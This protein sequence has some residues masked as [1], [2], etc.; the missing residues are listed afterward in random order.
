MLPEL[1][2]RNL[3]P[4]TKP[5]RVHHAPIPS[6]SFPHLLTQ[7]PS[8]PACTSQLPSPT[9]SSR[10]PATAPPCPSP[11]DTQEHSHCRCSSS[12]AA[13]HRPSLQ[14]Q[15]TWQ[16]ALLTWQPGCPT[17]AA[18]QASSRRPLPAAPP[19]PWRGSPRGE[20]EGWRGAGW[21]APLQVEEDGEKGKGNRREALMLTCCINEEYTGWKGCDSH[22]ARKGHRVKLQC[23]RENREF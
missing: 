7:S 22:R 23:H 13:L 11:P 2:C 20:W 16:Q 18:P 14:V 10:L 4:T 21:R 5:T 8:L 9:P 19:A 12:Q 17:S 6:S 1:P 3:P 15:L